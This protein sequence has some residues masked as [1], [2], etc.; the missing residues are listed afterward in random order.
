M[1]L[2]PL[3]N[4][5]PCCV[6]VGENF[7]E[8]KTETDS[9]DTTECPYDDELST[10]MFHFFVSISCDDLLHQIRPSAPSGV[11]S[12][13]TCFSSNLR[14]CW[15]VGS[16]QFVRRRCDCSASSAPF[17]NIQTYLLTYLLAYSRL[18]RTRFQTRAAAV[19][20]HMRVS[21]H[22]PCCVYAGCSLELQCFEIKTEADNS[23]I[24]DYD[25]MPSTGMFVFIDGQFPCTAFDF[26]FHV[27][28]VF[29]CTSQ[30]LVCLVVSD[31]TCLNQDTAMHAVSY[32]FQN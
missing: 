28:V 18:Q 20:V 21:V 16:A 13:P 29:P 5:C 8:I 10:G 2:L 22:L 12:R 4:N 25:D 17:T 7:F 1:Y 23:D 15:Q 11:I 30:A 3:K 31:N 6:S 19:C 32:Q 27:S 9:N 14:C 24:T 26:K